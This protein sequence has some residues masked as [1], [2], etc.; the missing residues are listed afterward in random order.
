MTKDFKAT[1]HLLFIFLLALS[2][3]RCNSAKGTYEIGRTSFENYSQLTWSE[4][5]TQ[6]VLN[7]NISCQTG[8][9]KLNQGKYIIRFRA[10][11]T[12]AGD[13]VLPHL[14]I[15]LGKYVVR[16]M[17]VADGDQQYKLKFELPENITAPL[18]LTFDNDFMNEQGDRNIFLYVPLSIRPY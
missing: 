6:L 18:Q 14:V 15:S 1:I 13:G 2:A 8:I 3:V 16:D 10:L 9:L 11:G 17:A 5:S 4:D 7:R 12:T